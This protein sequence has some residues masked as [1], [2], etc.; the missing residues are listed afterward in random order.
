MNKSVIS[1]T[2]TNLIEGRT[3]GTLR[4]KRSSFLKKHLGH[5]LKNT[6]QNSNQHITI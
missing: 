2:K 3:P 1:V 4:V 6:K 5:C